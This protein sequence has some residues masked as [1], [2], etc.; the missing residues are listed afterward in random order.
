MVG[1]F[2]HLG[3]AWCVLAMMQRGQVGAFLSFAAVLEIP[4]IPLALGHMNKEW[5]RDYTFGILFFITRVILHFYVV[6]HAFTTY[7]NSIFPLVPLIPLP[8]HIYWFTN[9]VRQ[10]LRTGRAPKTRSVPSSS[11]ALQGGVDG[12]KALRSK[13][14]GCEVAGALAEGRDVTMAVED[15]A[16]AAVDAAVGAAVEGSLGL[17][18]LSGL[19]SRGGNNTKTEAAKGR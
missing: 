12:D 2:H 16:A 3:Y 7:T 13:R 1:W 4:T 19:R 6:L 17:L 14:A 9:W 18:T 8:L 10:Q 15:T 11:S 5:R